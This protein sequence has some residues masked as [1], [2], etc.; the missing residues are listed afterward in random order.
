M[1]GL[2]GGRAGWLAGRFTAAYSARA[3]ALAALL[4][5]RHFVPATPCLSTRPPPTTT[6]ATTHTH[7]LPS[8][9][10]HSCPPA[11]PHPH[12]PARLP[13]PPARV[14]LP[15]RP[16]PPARPPAPTCP[17][18]PPAQARTLP[19]WPSAA[20][21]SARCTTRPS[22]WSWSSWMREGL[23][24]GAARPRQRRTASTAGSGNSAWAVPK[25]LNSLA[26]MCPCCSLASFM[27]G[28]DGRFNTP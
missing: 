1:G 2:M 13:A 27:Q 17:P 7:A 23:P 4:P 15:A 3:C 9:P 14:H 24:Q 16:R 28:V 26:G 19:S 20:T 8:S 6:P 18:S 21:R 5:C 11:H 10:P 22:R 12:R 25:L